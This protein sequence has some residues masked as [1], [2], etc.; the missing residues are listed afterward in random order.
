MYWMGYTGY[1][2]AGEN[3]NV[4]VPFRKGSQAETQFPANI[5][6]RTKLLNNEAVL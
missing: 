1:W 5:M 3:Q 6:V 2:F 4:E